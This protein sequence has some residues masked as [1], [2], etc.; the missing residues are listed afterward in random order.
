MARKYGVFAE[1]GDVLFWDGEGWK[2]KKTLNQ[3]N[4][5]RQ[6]IRHYCGLKQASRSIPV[7]AAQPCLARSAYPLRVWQEGISL[8]PTP[9]KLQ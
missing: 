4:D 3:A 1:D 5:Y 8:P 2:E 6:V 7:K 9:K